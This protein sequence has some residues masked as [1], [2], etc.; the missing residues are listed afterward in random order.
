MIDIILFIHCILVF[1][2]YLVLD[3]CFYDA[4]DKHFTLNLLV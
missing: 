2:F 1:L 3:V 4:F